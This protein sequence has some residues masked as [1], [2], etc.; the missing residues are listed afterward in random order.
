MKVRF[1]HAVKGFF[2]KFR[3]EGLVY[4]KY[5]DGALCLIR[6]YPYYTASEQ[7]H[8]IGNAGRNL[9]KLFWLISDD[10]K[11]DLR[12]YSKLMMHYIDLSEKIPASC[13]AHFIKMMFA[14]QK[15]IPAVDLSSITREEI[16][17]HEY[18][19]RI[20]VEAMKAGLLMDIPEAA[21]LI[22]EM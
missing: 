19:V 4:C 12:I 1:R 16:L 20:V 9:G 10:Y 17:E 18:P 6:K 14:L 5:N 21:L 13:Y 22:H 3:T 11:N 7:N 15:Q 2:G 8:K